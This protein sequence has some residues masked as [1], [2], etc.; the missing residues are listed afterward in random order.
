MA[1]EL[2]PR[3]QRRRQQ[4]WRGVAVFAVALALIAGLGWVFRGQLGLLGSTPPPT[5]TAPA[6]GA[7]APATAPSPAA[8]GTP[9]AAPA[10]ANLLATA[11]PTPAPAQPTP[12][13][14][15]ALAPTA[16]PEVDG[17]AGGG[18][19]TDPALVPLVDLLPAAEQVPDGLEASRT[20]ERDETE[21]VGSL[22]GEDEAALLEA[23]TLLDDWGWEGNA[24]RDFEGQ[25]ESGTY[26]LNVSVHRFADETAADNAL[27]FFSDKIL[28]A[29]YTVDDT[30]EPV[31]DAIRLLVGAP[32]GDPISVVYMR[33]GPVMYR[34]GGTAAAAVGDPTADVLAVAR[35]VAGQ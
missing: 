10:V 4:A 21:V 20:A 11:T 22:G 2:L 28:P 18:Q 7:A 13:P 29:G 9:T 16:P 25:T 33:V 12:G 17:N 34:I 30:V 3:Q 31:G 15:S 23:E 6:R 1:S 5:A 35:A 8:G 26:A 24:F 32:E 27:V 14:T 19:T